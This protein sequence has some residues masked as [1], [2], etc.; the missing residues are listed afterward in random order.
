MWRLSF[1][2]LTVGIHFSFDAKVD[3]K[4]FVKECARRSKWAT[5]RSRTKK[6]RV[7]IDLAGKE[8]KAGVFKPLA[9]VSAKPIFYATISDR[10]SH[11]QINGKFF[12]SKLVRVIFWLGII[13]FTAYEIIWINR[14]VHRYFEGLSAVDWLGFSLTLVPGPVFLFLALSV[15]NY[16]IRKH[17]QDFELIVDELK[18]IAT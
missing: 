2:L 17:A 3:T 15:L 5:I 6:P 4:T 18:R 11:P 12:Y 10:G 7:A 1:Q 14:L 9:S 16:S 13:G 8:L